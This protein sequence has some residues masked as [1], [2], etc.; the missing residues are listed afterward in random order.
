MPVLPTH[1]AAVAGA[2]PI[3]APGHDGAVLGPSDLVLCS[4]T[5]PRAATFVDRLEAAAAGGFAAISL[6]GR[7]YAAARRAGHS[8]ADLRSQLADRGLVVAEI[9][10]VWDWTPTTVDP[11]ALAAVDDMELFCFGAGDLLAIADAVGAR[12]VNA[13]DVLGGPWG[14]DDAT[15]AFAALCDRAAEHGLLVQLE[16]LPWS[17]IPDVGRAWEI[18]RGADR[19]NG[20][21]AVDAWH[22]F[23]GNP[24]IAAL[25]AVPGSKILGVQLADAPIAAEPNAMHAALHDRRLPGAG[26]L[27]LGALIAALREVGAVAPLGVEV[28]SDALHGL[29]PIE[30]GRRAGTAT[31]HLLAALDA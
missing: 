3:A 29:G 28:L 14:V 4:G 22:W 23:R 13:V 2:R 31:R 16:L 10:P 27:D 26:D 30:A 21:I 5:L 11:A 24:D 9:D 6:W 12:S 18:V 19:H 15:E 7:D 1:A 25:R 8:D 17:K 20:G